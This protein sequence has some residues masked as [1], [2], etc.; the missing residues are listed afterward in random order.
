MTATEQALVAI[1]SATLP[2]EGAAQTARWHALREVPL[3]L[4]VDIAL[5]AMSLRSLG[6]L[7]PGQVLPSLIATAEDLTIIIGGSPVCHARF[8]Y[9]EGRMSIRIT[10]LIGPSSP[11][12]AAA[13]F[14]VAAGAAA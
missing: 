3:R 13:T 8:E 1:S 12:A 2:A 4:S 7:Q 14:T 9:M 10:R 6:A 11:S 5:P